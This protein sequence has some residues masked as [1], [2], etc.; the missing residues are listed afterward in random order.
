MK[1]LKFKPT[2]ALILGTILTF[3]SAFMIN[4]AI[5]E[6]PFSLFDWKIKLTIGIGIVVLI[7]VLT[8]LGLV[9]K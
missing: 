4:D 9:K 1:R 7:M 3:L 5:G 6:S 8:R 2:I